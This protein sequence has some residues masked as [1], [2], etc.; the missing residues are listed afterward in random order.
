[1]KTDRVQTGISL[2]REDL[3]LKPYIRIGIF[4]YATQDTLPRLFSGLGGY[5]WNHL[6]IY[7][8]HAFGGKSYDSAARTLCTGYAVQQSDAF[9][10]SLRR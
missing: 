3:G 8:I 7:S 2:Q 9:R 4:L 5:S 10:I 6:R 1:M